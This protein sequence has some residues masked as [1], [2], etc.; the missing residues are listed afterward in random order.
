M[1]IA[2]LDTDVLLFQDIVDPKVLED[3]L[4][5]AREMIGR[6]YSLRDESDSVLGYTSGSLKMVATYDNSRYKLAAGFPIYGRVGRLPYTFRPE[7]LDDEGGEVVVVG[8]HFQSG[9]PVLPA[10]PMPRDENS[11]ASIWSNGLPAKSQN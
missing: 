2:N 10:R 5:Q 4:D 3:I 11:N 8:V 1:V 6:P 9:Y 7:S